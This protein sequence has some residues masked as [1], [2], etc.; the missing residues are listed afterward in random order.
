MPTPEELTRE[1]IDAL[2]QQ[3]GLIIQRYKQ[4]D[5]KLSSGYDR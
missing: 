2:L 5:L 3:G 1:Q 4:V